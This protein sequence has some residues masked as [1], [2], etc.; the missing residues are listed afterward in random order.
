MSADYLRVPSSISTDSLLMGLGKVQ[1]E[2][3]GESLLG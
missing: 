2:G 1:Q 3:G